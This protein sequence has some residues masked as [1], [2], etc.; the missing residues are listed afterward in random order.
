MAETELEIMV[1]WENNESFE[2]TIKE[3]DGE[4][5]TL[6]KMDENGNISALWPHASAVVAKYIEDLLVRIGAEMKAL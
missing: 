4:L 1:R 3:D 6:I 5:L 2:V